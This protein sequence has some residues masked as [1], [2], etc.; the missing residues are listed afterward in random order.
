MDIFAVPGLLMVRRKVRCPQGGQIWSFTVSGS[1][2]SVP[3]DF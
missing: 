3:K 2:K 1:Q